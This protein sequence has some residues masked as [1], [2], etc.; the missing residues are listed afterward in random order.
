MVKDEVGNMKSR[1]V[2]GKVTGWTVS[3]NVIGSKEESLNM[4]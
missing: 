1:E 3:K 2:G 4:H